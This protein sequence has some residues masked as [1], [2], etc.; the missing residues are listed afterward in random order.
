MVWRR[1]RTGT[2]S[3]LEQADIDQATVDASMRIVSLADG[4]SIRLMEVGSGECIV[5]VN[6]APELNFVFAPQI[7]EFS[8]DYRVILYEPRMLRDRSYTPD[9]RKKELALVAQALSLSSFHVIA[10]SDAGSGAY[11]FAKEMPQYVRSVTFLALADRYKLP[12]GLQLLARL[13]YSY[14]IEG[15]VPAFVS[16]ILLGVFLGGKQAK[17]SWIAKRALRIPEIT[18][19]LKFSLMPCM[20]E[21]RP[22]FGEVLCQALI[23]SGDK[24]PLVSAD[25]ARQM[26]QLLPN[27]VDVVI[28]PN[29]EHLLPYVNQAAVNQAVRDFL[30]GLSK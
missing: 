13:F 7:E 28:V 10:W 20:F 12:F 3:L 22:S 5:L 18:E 30:T 9:D 25:Q 8:Q 4:S 29:G 23:V 24:D 27:V 1:Y 21:H 11:L 2:I 26:A 16:S 14:P 6:T 17:R 15:V 19:L